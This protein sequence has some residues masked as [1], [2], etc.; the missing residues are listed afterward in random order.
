MKEPGLTR[1]ISVANHLM[2]VTMH[3]TLIFPTTT[4]Y[5]CT[6]TAHTAAHTWSAWAEVADSDDPVNTLSA[7]FASLPGHITAMVTHVADQ[8]DTDYMVKLAYGDA[9]VPIVMWRIH[10][11]TN[12]VSS[13][14]QSTIRAV[15]I[16]AGETIY[17]SAMC[18]TAG[19]PGKT[20]IVHFRYF[21]GT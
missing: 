14:G 11:A 20:L 5:I 12:K 6:L 3:S 2:A 15:H 1:I 4:A 17:Y 9:K 10:S 16:P 21:L 19:E 7:E 13:S 18:M 8:D